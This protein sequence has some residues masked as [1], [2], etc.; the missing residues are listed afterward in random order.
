MSVDHAIV[1]QKM[2]SNKRYGDP[3]LADWVYKQTRRYSHHPKHS[4]LIRADRKV[5][6]QHDA[7]E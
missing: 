4:E 1:Y 7:A 3:P 2:T 5:K 6:K